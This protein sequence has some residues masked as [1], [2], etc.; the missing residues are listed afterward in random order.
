M[1]KHYELY[2]AAIARGTAEDREKTRTAWTQSSEDICDLEVLLR[3]QVATLEKKIKERSG[4]SLPEWIG[5]DRDWQL[6]EDHLRN[7][8]FFE[9]LDGCKKHYE[10]IR[11][12]R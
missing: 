8:E 7:S 12:L 11:D 1:K 5:L 10:K 3:K 2:R 6:I 4:R 9:P